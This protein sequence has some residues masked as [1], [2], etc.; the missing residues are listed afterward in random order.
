VQDDFIY[1]AGVYNPNTISSRGFLAKTTS[2]G[3]VVWSKT[4][5]SAGTCEFND[6][7]LRDDTT[8]VLTGSVTGTGIGGKD[9]LVARFD[10]S[11]SLRWSKAY[12]KP[13]N[14]SG[15]AI[16]AASDAGFYV[17]GNIDFNDPSGDIFIL[18]LTA[19]GTVQWCKTYNIVHSGF[20]GQNA[21]DLVMNSSNQLVV[22]GNTKVYEITPSDQIWNPLLVKTDLAG[23]VIYA[24]E[25]EL[26]SGGGA[27][28]QVMETADGNFA[29]TG[30]MK[31]SFG[32][33][34]KTDQLG[35][36]S[37]SK[38]YGFDQSGGN[39]LNQAKS[40]IQH[41]SSFVMT[42]FVETQYDTALYLFKTNYKGESGCKESEPGLQAAPN[43]ETPAVNNLSLSV[44]SIVPGISVLP[45]ASFSPGPS[46]YTWCETPTG[47][48]TPAAVHGAYPNPVEDFLHLTGFSEASGYRLT[49]SRGNQVG[50]GHETLV[51]FRPFRAGVYFLTAWDRGSCIT[52]KIIRVN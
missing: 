50:A 8:L 1:L 43:A 38:V 37:W 46:Q 21:F 7:I 48:A 23:N 30:Y 6:L 4:F 51:D 36:T 35:A 39:Y 44:T 45:L 20:S 41:G 19:D 3:V 17:T 18:E 12:G 31:T 27:A 49:D 10:T 28:Y 16:I 2:A 5:A 33:L 32:L 42:G 22:S 52:Y 47:Y 34:V 14:E 24:K 40:F 29:F 26:N 15:S 9:I 13:G 11:G 25:Y